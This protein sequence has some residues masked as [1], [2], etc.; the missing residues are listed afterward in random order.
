MND[1]YQNS[2]VK[3]LILCFGFLMMVTAFAV[4]DEKPI[5]LGPIIQEFSEIDTILAET[6][7]G[8]CISSNGSSENITYHF[9]SLS[10]LT[11]SRVM[12]DLL[13]RFL[14]ISNIPRVGFRESKN[15]WLVGKIMQLYRMGNCGAVI[16][17]ARKLPADLDDEDV[18]RV[19]M[20]SLFL[21]EGVLDKFSMNFS[22]ACEIAEKGLTAFGGVNWQA[23]HVFC[24]AL[25]GDW[26]KAELGVSLLTEQTQEHLATQLMTQWLGGTKIH[27]FASIDFL[28]LIIAR[29]LNVKL[30][31]DLFESSLDI[32]NL[33]IISNSPKLDL[34]VRVDAMERLASY[35]LAPHQPI[36]DIYSQ[37][38]VSSKE[39]KVVM[40]NKPLKVVT[41]R[42]GRVL[43]FQAAAKSAGVRRSEI[44]QRLYHNLYDV[45]YTLVSGITL[46][47]LK[48]IRPDADLVWFAL[49]AV[50][51]LLSQ[52][53]TEAA[54]EWV[55]LVRQDNPELFLEITPLLR[56][57]GINDEN[58]NR[59]QW[60]KR[61]HK[62]QTVL[63]SEENNPIPRILADLLAALD[64]PIN[65]TLLD[66]I[67]DPRSI[68]QGE[69]ITAMHQL[70][71]M[72]AAVSRASVGEAVVY[73]YRALALASESEK[74]DAYI[75]IVRSLYKLGLKNEA[76]NLAVEAFIQARL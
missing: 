67:L 21:E 19:V 64:Q 55:K 12:N 8:Q 76:H 56:L 13:K 71:K 4:A 69:A 42:M 50:R 40:E 3:Y 60:F 32:I 68:T 70:E 48:Q 18:L 34:R 11:T 2:W 74:L 5:K 37:H 38:R 57:A 20:N 53:E 33:K 52:G 41:P 75:K 6:S 62:V 22:K 7:K 15:K 16:E 63:S 45:P 23:A 9:Q 29:H 28:S 51:A 35:C 17:M 10:V 46:P 44:L 66:R 30:P 65:P 73:A 47:L 72:Q 54:L 31:D 14:L 59:T 49:D 36:A 27:N 39:L 25:Q 1:F 26:E 61:W 24:Q 58:E 43:L